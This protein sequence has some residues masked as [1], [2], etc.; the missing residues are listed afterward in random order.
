LGKV[1][2]GE[3]RKKRGKDRGSVF[4]CRGKDRER[5]VGKFP[6]GRR[7]RYGRRVGADLPTCLGGQGGKK[8]KMQKKKTI[9]KGR[10]FCP[11]EEGVSLGEMRRP[12]GRK[13]TG[14]KR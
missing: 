11:G 9:E 1:R 14:K 10:K 4:I 13:K 7:L 6:N 5:G 12:G 2:R 3:Q 8:K